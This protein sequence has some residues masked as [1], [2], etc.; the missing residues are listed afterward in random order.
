MYLLSELRRRMGSHLA[1]SHF[2]CV[3][4]SECF[5]LS[6]PWNPTP[7]FFNRQDCTME[8][9]MYFSPSAPPELVTMN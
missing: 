2:L 3:P 4:H 6:F 7:S 5:S 8:T 1:H 9:G